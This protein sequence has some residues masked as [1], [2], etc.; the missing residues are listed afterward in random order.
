M[1]SLRELSDCV[2][3]STLTGVN[4]PQIVGSDNGPPDVPLYDWQ[5]FL[6]PIFRQVPGIKGHHHFSFSAA[7]TGVLKYREFWNSENKEHTMLKIPA[8]KVAMIM[9]FFIAF[10][11]TGLFFIGLDWIIWP[12]IARML[13]G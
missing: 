1:S 12:H 13:I 11:C 9:V 2:Q 10:F 6:A 5:A 3:A 8:A 7:A 4:I